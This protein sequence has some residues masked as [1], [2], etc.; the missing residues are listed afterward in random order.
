MAKELPYFKFE[1]GAWDTGNIQLCTHEQKGVFIDLCALYWQRLSDLPYKLAVQK[2]CGGNATA[3]DSLYADKI[4]D[5]QDGFICIDFLNEQLGEFEN[6][7][8]INSENAKKGWIKR[9]NANPM[10]PHS[11][12]NAIREEK[13]KGEKI[14]KDNTTVI[15]QLPFESLDFWNAWTEWQQYKK[16]KKQRLTESTAKKQLKFLGAKPE[17]IAI[18]IIEQSITHGWAGLFELKTQQNG[19]GFNKKQQQTDELIISHAKRWGS[20]A[21]QAREV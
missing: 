21:P 5:I 7:G 2:V 15:L 13:S 20:N 8:K 19:T 10:R 6:T 18:L 3:L 17:K 1:P 9:K 12:P 16:E 11:D 14:K 4:I